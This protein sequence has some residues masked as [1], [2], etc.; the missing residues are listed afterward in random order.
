VVARRKLEET[1]AN[2][3]A[4]SERPY[5]F[6]VRLVHDLTHHVPG[7]RKHADPASIRAEHETRHKARAAKV[8]AHHEARSAAAGA[9]HRRPSDDG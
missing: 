2:R 4:E 9:R 5:P 6:V 3:A 7:V 1:P 8:K